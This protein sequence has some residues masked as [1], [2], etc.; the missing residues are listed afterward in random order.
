M[1]VSHGDQQAMLDYSLQLSSTLPDNSRGGVGLL[2]SEAI[3]VIGELSHVAHAHLLIIKSRLRSTPNASL[4]AEWS[5]TEGLPVGPSLQDVPVPFFGECAMT[6]LQQ[7]SAFFT[8]FDERKNACSKLV[9]GLLRELNLSS[10]EMIPVISSGELT[11]IIGLAHNGDSEFLCDQARR[12]IQL[13]GGVLMQSVLFARREKQRR[14]SHTQWKRVAN[15]ACDFALRVN[16]QGEIIGA[17]PFR[18]T[19]PPNV[20]GLLLAE[21]V[22]PSSADAVRE[23]IRDA[24]EKAE[25]RSLQIFGINTSGRPCSYAVRVEPPAHKSRSRVTTLY[26]TNNDVE[27]AHEAQLCDLRS[28]L[29]RAA[30]LSILGNIAT[31]FAHQL[32]QPLQA[33]SNHVFTIMSRVKKNESPETILKCVEAVET[34]ANHAGDIIRSLRDF[35]TNRRVP[36]AA[37]PLAKMITHAVAMVEVQMDR[38]GTV[39]QIRDPEELLNPRHGQAVYV[40]EVQTTHVLI[41]LLMNAMEACS[42]ADILNPAIT[43]TVRLDPSRKYAIVEV[44]DNGPGILLENP[45]GVFDRFFT[46]KAEGFGIGLAICR[47][48][49]ERQHGV[50]HARNNSDKGCCFWFTSPLGP[51]EIKPTDSASS[52]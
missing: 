43:I 29:S 19:N 4:R 24:S 30:R 17:L 48:V 1:P 20:K 13:T 14:R 11:A 49:I 6:C 32:A 46:T 27:R 23:M 31:E 34:S 21:F 3:R 50:I 12:L 33:I 18:Q 16:A 36:I 10:Y 5:S 2:A 38:F 52:V 35:V 8:T 41:N 37:V 9:S 25:P 47:D 39:V 40:D 44:S 26:L 22:S 51:P 28:Q 42:D 15:G 7:G 45:D